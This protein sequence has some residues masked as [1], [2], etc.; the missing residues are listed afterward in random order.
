MIWLKIGLKLIWYPLKLMRVSIQ[1]QE[2][3]P[4]FTASILN[5]W[6]RATRSSFSIVSWWSGLTLSWLNLFAV[7]SRNGKEESTATY[8]TQESSIESN[9]SHPPSSPILIRGCYYR[10]L[11]WSSPI[12]ISGCYYLSLMWH[13]HHDF[14]FVDQ[15]YKSMDLFITTER[16]GPISTVSQDANTVA[17]DISEH[18]TGIRYSYRIYLP[19]GR[20][21]KLLSDYMSRAKYPRPQR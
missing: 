18:S 16:V 6:Y 17:I 13:R 20:A 1:W 5:L 15:H 8:G 10:S 14:C 9:P 2:I 7:F 19:G 3:R 11:T 21:C 4:L 12:N